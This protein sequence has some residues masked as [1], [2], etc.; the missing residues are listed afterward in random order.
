LDFLW[1]FSEEQDLEA[2]KKA[3]GGKNEKDLLEINQLPCLPSPSPL[4]QDKTHK[5][6]ATLPTKISF[7][8]LT[9]YPKEGL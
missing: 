7:S 5:A 6:D 1:W 9:L 2:K 4:P 3:K 8:R